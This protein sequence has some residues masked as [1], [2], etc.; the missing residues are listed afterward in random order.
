MLEVFNKYND[1]LFQSTVVF[2][3]SNF[4]S[5]VIFQDKTFNTKP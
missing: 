1:I 2:Y 3:T 4:I 5:E